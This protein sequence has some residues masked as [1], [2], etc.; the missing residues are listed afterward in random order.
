M[1]ASPPLRF[2]RRPARSRVRIAISWLC[3]L[4]VPLGG[5]ARQATAP[6]PSGHVVRDGLGR[7][8]RLPLS[9]RRI[10][11][12]APSVTDSLLALGAG[13]RLVGITDFCRLPPGAAPRARVRG[14]LHPHLE[15]SRGVRPGVLVRTNNGY[16]PS[17]G[18]QTASLPLPP[19]TIHTA[20][21]A[22]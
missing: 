18:Q 14:M 15:T 12:L 1:V 6:S 2:P 7:E 22:S 3:A 19:Y 13:E 8:V 9:P 4:L 10:V 5:C 11:S 16:D 20:D 21:A 17:L